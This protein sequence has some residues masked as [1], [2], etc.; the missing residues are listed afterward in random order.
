MTTASKDGKPGQRALLET[1]ESLP[2]TLRDLVQLM[3][4]IYVRVDAGT[5]AR[6]LDRLGLRQPNG[7]QL[8]P[9][10]VREHLA[11]LLANGLVVQDGKGWRCSP[12]VANA[13]TRMA[14]DQGTF[15]V[16]HDAVCSCCPPYSTPGVGLG[17]GNPSEELALCQLRLAMYDG[18]L[19]KV[20]AMSNIY[21]RRHGRV[22]YLAAVRLFTPL[23]AAWFAAREPRWAPL[24]VA[25]VRDG[26]FNLAS[27]LE[28]VEILRQHLAGVE[29]DPSLQTSLSHMRLL[30]A[31]QLMLMGQ[32][33][34]AMAI[35]SP[36]MEAARCSLLG[37]LE[38][39]RGAHSRALEHYDQGVD[40]MADWGQQHFTSLAAPFHILALAVAGEDRE[41]EAARQL[42]SWAG[43]GHPFLLLED[44]LRAA[45]AAAAGNPR[46]ARALLSKNGPVEELLPLELIFHAMAEV[47]VDEARAARL[48]PL[49]EPV[50]DQ[51]EQSGYLVAAALA[52]EVLGR[53]GSASRARQGAELRRLWQGAPVVDL[54]RPRPLW[55]HSLEALVGIGR[56]D[57]PRPKE[58][59]VWRVSLLPA[60]RLAT[61]QPCIQ[62]VGKR[63]GWTRGRVVEPRKL[64]TTRKLSALLTDQD[65]RA[66]ASMQD[67]H[68]YVSDLDLERA[69][70]ALV[71]HPLVFWHDRPT[72]P[73]ELVEGAPELVITRDSGCVRLDL[74]PSPFFQD[75]EEAPD[76]L[77]DWGVRYDHW[78]MEPAPYEV[79]PDDWQR[80]VVELEGPSRLRITHF[81]DEHLRIAEVLGEEGL[82]VPEQG[83][84]RVL[85]VIEAVAPSITVQ[86]DIG[87]K[88][89]DATSA[90]APDSRPR[91]LLSPLRDG[92]R[93]QLWVRPLDRGGPYYRPGEGGET[94]VA[95]LEGARVR[96]RR[97]RDLE[98]ALAGAVVDRCPSLTGEDPLAHQWALPVLE[99]ALDALLELQDLGDDVVV[100]WPEGQALKLPRRAGTG[101][102]FMRLNRKG[103]WFEADGSLQLDEHTV[104]QMQDL[105][106]LEELAK[107]RFIPL[108]DGEF[109]ALTHDLRKRL[110]DL[111]AIS[112]ERGE[113]LRFSPLAAPL[114]EDL[115]DELGGLEVDAAWEEQLRRIREAADFSPRLPSTLRATLRDYQREG[116]RWLA[117]LAH[118]G[119]GA[120]LADDMGLGKTVQALAVILARAA[121]GPTLVVAPTSVAGNWVREALRFAP[122]LRAHTFTSHGRQA[123]LGS[124]GPRDMLICSYGLL[125][126]ECEGLAGVD[127]RTVVLDEA[128][129][130]KNAATKSSR[131]AMKLRGGFR[132][133]TTGTPIEN[134]LGELWNL[135]RFINPGLL[136]SR[137]S[138]DARFAVPIEKHGDREARHRLGRLVRPF[139]L[140]RTKGQVLEEL[141]ARTE[142]NV[143]VQMSEEEQ[144]FYEALR[145][146]ALGRLEDKTRP[147]H[148]QVLAE[149]M[150][151]RRA[152]CNP[153]LVA[154]ETSIPSAKLEAFGDLLSDLMA[155]GHRAL[156]FS[157]FV[158]HLAIVRR[159]LEKR[160]VEYKYLD[161][162]TPAAERTRQVDAFQAGEGDVFLISL[163]AGGLG[164]NLT[165]ADYVIHLD[166]WWNPAVEDQASDR[167]HRIGQRRPVTIYRLVVKDTIEEKI[168]A[169]HRD[170]RDLAQRLLEGTDSAGKL[171]AEELMALL[172]KA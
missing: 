80:V 41:R 27:P 61:L 129:T 71:G 167:A 1:F 5:L 140:R 156:V 149:L 62:R 166:P 171:T 123:M 66:L 52:S 36:T 160:K 18:D 3:S 136:G 37:W 17:Y 16:L 133:I 162:S 94:V 119:V 172:R 39:L 33:D 164:L 105:L 57:S 125:R 101:Q 74:A 95:E 152:C 146:E 121:D 46:Q 127:W 45:V 99:A 19:H 120:C 109:V 143:D 60:E 49:L 141:P 53:T 50:A 70:P 42:A 15:D 115:A 126:V 163:K 161:G 69:L 135:F 12:T 44:P 79:R 34:E 54:F 92:V 6:C 112:E 107:G 64:I 98:R 58:R 165:G 77:M 22:G 116:F 157:Q 102:L 104:L 25:S 114:L 118:W 9:R 47:W 159:L 169:L 138:F 97:D 170:K 10:R 145:R 30:T 7:A 4:M 78:E 2:R 106:R 76:S 137:R 65:R 40:A 32:P 103:D 68:W 113:G 90:V 134:H 85:D 87:A 59:L 108:G 130:I 139:I 8:P 55:E 83:E 38:M 110:G 132:L 158:A 84:R 131:A 29:D 23:D 35:L 117:R 13:A 72:E 86:S 82:Q 155:N 63:G 73:V 151:L 168:V 81:S 96:T 148:I 142:V 48:A 100:E 128:Q 11:P 31:E 122:T 147:G 14:V 88:E 24:L 21:N 93:A 124:L 111:R 91:F 75:H 26:L 150:R 89:T 67:R 144:A 51:A 20:E 43:K 153:A 154:P 56:V 28:V